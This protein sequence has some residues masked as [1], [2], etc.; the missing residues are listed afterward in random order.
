[1]LKTTLLRI[2]HALPEHLRIF[3]PASGPVDRFERMRAAAGALFGLVI[4]GYCTFFILGADSPS[5]L[6]LLAPMGASSVLLFAVPSSPLAQPWSI[7]GGNLIASLVGVTCV[8]I[9]G[10]TIVAAGIAAGVA[11]AL[12]IMLRCIH[13]PSGAVALT[14]VLGGAA[15]HDLGYFFVL[16]PIMLNSF[17]LLATALFYN[18][19]TGRRYPH[20]GL[21]AVPRDTKDIAPSERLGVT[22]ADI[23]TILASYNQVLAVTREDLEEILQRAEILAYNR[24]FGGTSCADI[25]SKHLITAEFGTTLAEAWTLLHDNKVTALPVI[26]R[27]RRLIGIV[28]KADFFDHADIHPQK[29]FRQRLS[30]MVRPSK[31]S[32]TDKNEVVGQIMTNKVHVATAEQPITE[33]VSLM[34]DRRLHQIPVVN[35][36]NVLIGIITQT[37]MIAAL[38][39]TALTKGSPSP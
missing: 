36:D 37:D 11:I 17:L 19:S 20:V 25:M 16:S 12:M 35:D 9:F 32:H 8:K 10:G 24:R 21:A 2:H 22:Q 28:T 38:Y 27:G 6:W 15:V 5:A 30:N 23:D 31:D 7:I 29:G 39:E 3:F 13:P 4:T 18:N 14:T 33:L 1:M 34:S 26:N